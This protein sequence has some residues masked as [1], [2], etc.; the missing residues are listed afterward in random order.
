MAMITI[1]DVAQHA[2]VSITT[3]SLVLNGKG[4]ISE[5][6]RERVLD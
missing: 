3:A 5:A 6:T 2:G 4:N 1:K